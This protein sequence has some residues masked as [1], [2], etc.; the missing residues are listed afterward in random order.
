MTTVVQFLV[1]AACFLA[2]DA[3]WLAIMSKRLYRPHIGELMRDTPAWGA[4]ALFYAIYTLALTVLAVMPAE[5]AGAPALAAFNGAFMGLAAYATYN[6]TNAATL[7]HW[8]TPVIVFDTLWGT[9]ASGVA[10]WLATS[11]L[12]RFA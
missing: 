2:L 4:A 10:A 11:L 6:L 1:T 12:I 8:P 9:V 3:P 7:K 5:R